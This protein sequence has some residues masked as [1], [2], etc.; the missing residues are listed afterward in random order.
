MGIGFMVIL[1]AEEAGKAVHALELEGFSA[2]EIGV[3]T[4]E[5]CVTV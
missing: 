4:N 5:G 2:F 3:V 1:S